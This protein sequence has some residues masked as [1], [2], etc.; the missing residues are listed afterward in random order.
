MIFSEW[1]WYSRMNRISITHTHTHNQ[2]YLI[3]LYVKPFSWISKKKDWLK[4]CFLFMEKRGDIVFS[5]KVDS[6]AEYSMKIFFSPSLF[7]KY[8]R[9]KVYHHL[10]F[11][12]LG[13]SIFNSNA[14]IFSLLRFFSWFFLSLYY[15]N[16]FFLL[17]VVLFGL[18]CPNNCCCLDIGFFFSSLLLTI[19]IMFIRFGLVRPT[20]LWLWW[21]IH[22][23]TIELQIL[24]S[25][26]NKYKPQ[27]RY[28]H[29]NISIIV[30][31]LINWNRKK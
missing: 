18:F 13:F 31:V 20:I 16:I 24:N 12:Y 14:I 26:M 22:W 5:N 7:V 19:L 17:L 25:M 6:V 23:F 3:Y 11:K 8:R 21:Y 2:V 1:W 29:T 15:I 27:I 28:T 4:C 10:L 30:K 9:K